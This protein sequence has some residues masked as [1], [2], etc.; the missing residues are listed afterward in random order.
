VSNAA[1]LA[2]YRAALTAPGAGWPVLASLL[3]R[4]PVAMGSI[5]ILVYVQR[6]TGTF[7]SAGLVSAGALV[8]VAVGSVAQ[9]RLI[10]RLGPTRPLL[11]VSVAFAAVV[12]LAV[13]AV[14]ARAPLAVLV[15]LALLAGATQPAV[16]AASRALWAR[17]VPAGPQRQAAYSYEAISMETFFVLGPGLAGLLAAAPWAGTGVVVAAGCMLLGAVSFALTGTVRAWRPEPRTRPG[18]ALD[19]ALGGLAGP[20]MRT[21][22]IAALGFGA[23]IGVVEVAVPASATLAGYPAVGGLLLGT[24]SVSSV[25]CGIGYSARPWPRPLHLRVPVLLA[26]F[27]AGVSVLAIPTT[28]LG[29]GLAMLVAGALITP[30]AIAH[31]AVIE[32]VAPAGAVAEAFGWVI[33]AVTLGL[34]AGQSVS[35]Q[36]VETVGPRAAFLAGTAGGLALAGILWLRRRT[37]LPTPVDGRAPG[38]PPVCTTFP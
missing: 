20:G 4:L 21:L 29:L 11:A 33:T 10:D 8:G 25:I 27:A 16:S 18:R 24:W 37:L 14:E 31:S 6:T 30:Q 23:V 7:A 15:G 38:G 35:G 32:Q 13:L 2:D 22:V 19:G 26:G 36:L 28:L 9:G 3:A 17:L 34:A 12:T 1:T 5:A